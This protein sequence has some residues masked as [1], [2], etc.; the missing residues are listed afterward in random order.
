MRCPVPFPFRVSQDTMPKHSRKKQKISSEKV[1]L[2]ATAVD[3]TDDALKDDEERRLES[4][5]F[6]VP[7]VPRDPIEEGAGD[8][9]EGHGDVTVTGGAGVFNNLL[10]SDLFFV[11]DGVGAPIADDDNDDS[12]QL[13]GS[14]DDENSHSAASSSSSSSS[15]PSS[16]SNSAPVPSIQKS[17][18]APAWTDPSDPLVSLSAPRLRKLR[19]APSETSLPSRTYEA[20]LRRQYERI[21]PEPAW[22]SKARL[23]SKDKDSDADALEELL[24]ETGGILEGKERERRGRVELKSGSVELERLRDANLEVQDKGCGE[25]RVVCFHPSER[26]PVLCVGSADR[27]VRLFN[28]DGHTNPLL[29]TLHVPSLP[30][31]SPSSVSFHPSGNSLLLTGPRP[32]F[33]THDLQSGATTRHARGLWGTTFNSVTSSSASL[34]RGRNSKDG[35]GKGGEGGEGMELTAFSERGDVLAV[36]GRGG[37]VHLVD[38]A[39]GAGQV[40]GSLKCGGGGGG[41]R[42]LWWHRGQGGEGG[43]EQLAVLSGDAEVYLW[44]VGERRCVRRWKDEGGFRG[45]G[46]AMAGK[47]GFLAVGSNTGFVNVYGADSFA[48]GDLNMANPK[49]RKS[50]AN[51]TTSISAIRFNHDAQLMAVASQE[52]KDAM[53]LI[54]TPTLTS[55]ANWPTAGTP[56]GHVSAID[57]SARSEYLAIGNTRG[58]VLLYHLKDYGTRV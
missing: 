21:N 22:A 15:R 50:I 24:G 33:Y 26:V 20:R 13:A 1:P 25:A 9:E 46:R 58:R 8:D 27:R 51:L 10:D 11:D 32:F 42:A 45:A 48:T 23:A 57:F 17:R 18:S 4:L 55:F 43:R 12:E 5:L 3:L 28:I 30:L 39:S 2:G 52:K 44:D 54:H 41:V 40:V 38:W 6:G 56:L 35:T 47:G 49:P 19:D 34:K 31:T 29:Q 37:Y 36:A 16:P 7:Y 14:S 53:R